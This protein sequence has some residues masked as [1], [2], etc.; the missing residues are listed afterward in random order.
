MLAKQY[1]P[2]GMV[3]DSRNPHTIWTNYNNDQNLMGGIRS[4]G[5]TLMDDGT[6]SVIYHFRNLHEC[7]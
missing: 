1:G 5:A 2:P 3:A 4:I 7:I 6:I